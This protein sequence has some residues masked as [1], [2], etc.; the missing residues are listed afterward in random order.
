MRNSGRG[1]TSPLLV[2][3]VHP[4]GL[5]VT[6][7]GF[8]VGRRVGG[9]VV[10]NKVKR[11]LREIVRQLPVKAGWDVVFIARPA[12]AGAPF[13]QLGEAATD[14]LTRARLLTSAAESGARG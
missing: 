7:T 8:S 11:R 5:D 10:R 13:L 4:N 3:R 1:W 12:S 9:A 6:R 14:L 2:L